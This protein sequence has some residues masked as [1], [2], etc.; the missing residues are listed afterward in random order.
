MDFIRIW[1]SYEVCLWLCAGGLFVE[2]TVISEM[3]VRRVL[4]IG[5]NTSLIFA[6]CVVVKSQKGMLG[7]IFASMLYSANLDHWGC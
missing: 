6:G 4:E 5:H 3:I 1:K 2:Q 7:H